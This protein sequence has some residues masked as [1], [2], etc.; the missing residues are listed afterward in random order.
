MSPSYTGG[1]NIALKVPAHQHELTV[2]FYRDTLGL[3]QLDEHESGPVFEFGTNRLWID[4]EEGMS[5]AEIWLEVL[6]DDSGAAARH[7]AKRGIVRCDAI[8]AL[9]EDLQ[10]F[11]ISSPASIIHLVRRN[12]D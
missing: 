4:R 10:G 2:R 8:E 6:V 1:R 5:Q 3:K 11:W 12:K 9:P 7:L